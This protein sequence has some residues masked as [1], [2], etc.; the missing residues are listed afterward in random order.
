MTDKQRQNLLQYLGYYDGIPDGAW[1]PKSQAACRAF[2]EGFGGI[3]QDGFGGP[4]TDKALKHAVAMGFLKR[5][6]ATDTNVGSKD[7]TG[8]FWDEIEFFDREEFRCQCGGKY[9]NGFPNEPHEATV[10]FADAIRRRLGKPIH[11]NSGLRCPT[12]NSIQGGV[13]NS[14]HMTGGAVDLGCPVGVTPAEMKEAA[15]EVMGNTGGIGIY[16]WGIHID[17][18]VYSRW[19][20]RV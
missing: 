10:S 14:N 15:E 3:A 7:K 11:V 8:T 4:E 16:D 9:C 5:E 17:D 13:A 12:W 2:Q 20:E 19:D 18:G 1:G 6:D